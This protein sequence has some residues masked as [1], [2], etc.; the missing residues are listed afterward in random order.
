MLV[1]TGVAS[2]FT[3][4]HVPFALLNR[5]QNQFIDPKYHP[6]RMQFK[7]PQNMTKDDLVALC[8][9][10]CK[11]QEEHGVAAAFRFI[12]YYNGTEMVGA[13]YGTR[14]DDDRAAIR[15]RTEKEARA[16]G[17]RDIPGTR[18]GKEPAASG[19]DKSM[20][21]PSDSPPPPVLSA[22]LRQGP[23]SNRQH[24]ETAGAASGPS[25]TTASAM[26]ELTPVRRGFGLNAPRPQEPS[27]TSRT[28]RPKRVQVEPP[29]T[30]STTPR[31]LRSRRDQLEPPTSQA[32]PQPL[33]RGRRKRIK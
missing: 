12:G 13:E 16:A 33:P 25:E 3:R 8:K 22:G 31:T 10:I 14:A 19:C 28:L 5:Q 32:P 2:G 30:P 23:G 11:R 1:P 20:P 21:G 6:R 18:K 29:T 24:K 17:H 4:K 7:D 15:A 26:P 9:H 27:T